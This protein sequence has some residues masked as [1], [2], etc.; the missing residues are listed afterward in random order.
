MK[1]KL[2]VSLVLIISLFVLNIIGINLIEKASLVNNSILQAHSG[3]RGWAEQ[4]YPVHCQLCWSE[5]FE[6]CYKANMLPDLEVCE[7]L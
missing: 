3:H 7:H 6:G 5:A 2:T 4:I 1:R